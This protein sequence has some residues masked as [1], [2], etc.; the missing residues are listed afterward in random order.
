MFTICF[1][2]MILGLYNLTFGCMGGV[3]GSTTRNLF[4]KGRTIVPS[5][6][7]IDET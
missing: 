3:D 2:F 5:S 7:I 6:P 1:G 4:V